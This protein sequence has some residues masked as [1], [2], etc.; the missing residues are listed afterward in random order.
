MVWTRQSAQAFVVEGEV[1]EILQ[2]AGELRAKVVLRPGTVLDVTV[3]SPEVH[4]GDRVGIE[5]TMTV[6]RFR[7]RVEDEALAKGAGRL[8]DG[9]RP[10]GE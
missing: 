8:V 4:L 3:S 9:V 6:E 2:E 1:V 10:P 5:G 7:T